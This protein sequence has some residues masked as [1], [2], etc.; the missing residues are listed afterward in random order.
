LGGGSVNASAF[1]MSISWK[2][3]GYLTRQPANL[4]YILID[5]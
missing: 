5:T 4:V 1:S 2:R 3:S